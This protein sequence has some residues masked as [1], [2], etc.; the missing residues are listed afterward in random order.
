MRTEVVSA[1]GIRQ[2]SLRRANGSPASSTREAAAEVCD[3][4]RVLGEKPHLEPVAMQIIE[5][6]EAITECFGPP[7][8]DGILAFWNFIGRDGST[9]GT[10]FCRVRGKQRD[11]VFSV[12]A[13]AKTITAETCPAEV[14]HRYIFDSLANVSNGSTPMFLGAA[15]YEIRRVA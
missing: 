3:F 8:R 7:E 15:K 1:R 9:R 4:A 13:T 2:P 14:F 11:L 10:I 12:A 6:L 5:A